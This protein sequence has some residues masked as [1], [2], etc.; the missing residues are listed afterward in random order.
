ML[1]PT[2]L[3]P[4]TKNIAKYLGYLAFPIPLYIY[5]IC[6]N[7]QPTLD[8]EDE[9]YLMYTTTKTMH[10]VEPYLFI[11]LFCQLSPI[12][13]IKKGIIQSMEFRSTR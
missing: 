4:I 3:I 9:M 8:F 6:P 12:S 1:L 10:H 2:Q 11:E 13:I 5:E 7:Q